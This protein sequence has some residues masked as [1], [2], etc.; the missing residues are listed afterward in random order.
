MTWL[1][2]GVISWTLFSIVLAWE[3]GRFFRRVRRV[4]HR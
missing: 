3:A 1:M 2:L 4:R